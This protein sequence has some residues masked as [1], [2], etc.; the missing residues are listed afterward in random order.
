MSDQFAYNDGSSVIPEGTFRISPS[1]LSKFFD[2]TSKWYRENLLNEEGF[3]GSTSTHLGNCVHAAAETYAHTSKVDHK[4]IKDYISKITDPEVDK[5]IIYEQYPYMVDA[6]IDQYLS[7]H[8]HKEFSTELFVVADVLPEVVVGGSIDFYTPE[9][10]GII[11]DYKTMGSLDK[12]RLPQSFPRA[13][14]F[15]QLTYA[16][17]LRKLGKPVDRIQLV[18]VTRNNTGRFNDKGKPLKDYPSTVHVVTE[19]V[20]EENMEFIESVLHL[21][22]ESVTLWKTHPEY[23]HIIAQD[24]RLKPSPKPKIFKLK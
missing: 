20:T 9:A 16:W 2:T 13:Y 7:T 4:A 24:Q 6:L 1:Q 17:A 11:R 15:Q 12:A 10:G 18:Y 8:K 23:A 21:V 3:T 19:M 14:Y 22:A 5:S